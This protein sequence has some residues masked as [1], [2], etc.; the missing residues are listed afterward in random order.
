MLLT[1][2]LLGTLP[3]FTMD[4][5][6]KRTDQISVKMVHALNVKEYVKS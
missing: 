1:F 3:S 4:V 5:L 2:H 6:Y